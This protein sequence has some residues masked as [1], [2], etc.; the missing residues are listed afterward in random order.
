MTVYIWRDKQPRSAAEQMAMDRGMVHLA[1]DTDDTVV[2]LYQWREATLSFGANEAANRTWN[3]ELLDSEGVPTVRRPTGGRG[4]WHDQADLTYSWAGPTSGPAETARIYRNLHIQLGRVVSSL[5]VTTSLAPTPDSPSGLSP[6][7][8][9]ETALGGELL[10]GGR[11]LLG[12]AQRVYGNHLLQH[13]SFANREHLRFLGRFRKDG[14]PLARRSQEVSLPDADELGSAIS[15]AWLDGGAE[16]A[17]AELTDSITEL[18]LQYLPHF[19]NPEWT[20]RR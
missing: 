13:G 20:W 17:P 9:F 11:K 10:A 5:G 12:S 19:E 7:A 3:R 6:G 16:R 2:R 18:S 14:L 4:V 8:C 1:N 15:A